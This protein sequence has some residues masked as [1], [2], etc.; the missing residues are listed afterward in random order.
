M[1]TCL[2][3]L[4]RKAFDPSVPDKRSFL[5]TRAMQRDSSHSSTSHAISE[6]DLQRTA[7]LHTP[8]SLVFLKKRSHCNS[9]GTKFL[10]YH[11]NVL[12]IGKGRLKRF[13]TQNEDSPGQGGGR[14]ST[15]PPTLRQ[16][17][18]RACS[19]PPPAPHSLAEGLQL[20]TAFG[21][22]PHARCGLHH[23]LYQ[24]SI[25]IC[26]GLEVTAAL[27]AH[28]QQFTTAGGRPGPVQVCVHL[29]SQL[30][31]CTHIG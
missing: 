4:R 1:L 20:F 14:G 22:Q 16:H 25:S 30:G 2:L 8:S 21:A 7:S 12:T 29:L 27:Y 15:S 3:R 24:L 9:S 17:C 26:T 23:L 31:V 11:L 6:P 28:C 13:G 5:T 18:S 10:A 19:L